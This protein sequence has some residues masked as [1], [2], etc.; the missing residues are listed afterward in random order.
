MVVSLQVRGQ[1]PPVYL[2]ANAPSQGGVEAVPKE[3]VELR[4]VQRGH[5]GAQVYHRVCHVG[6]VSLVGWPRPATLLADRP[7]HVEQRVQKAALP[8]Q[9]LGQ[10]QVREHL[11]PA[12]RRSLVSLPRPDAREL[13]IERG[14]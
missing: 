9:A 8:F 13:Q 12:I 5:G 10:S 11:A 14:L 1:T 6:Q 4:Q 2:V 3:Q 7:C